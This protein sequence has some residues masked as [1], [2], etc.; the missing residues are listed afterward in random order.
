MTETPVR[1]RR[2]TV[3]GVVV[4]DKMHKTIVIQVERTVIHPVFKKYLRR[5]SKLT[6]HDANNDAGVGDKV[7]IM[8]T[9]P[10]SKTKSFRLVRIVSKAKIPASTPTIESIETEAPGE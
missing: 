10:I 3:T 2:R 4:S 5:R 7:E 6:A 1:S 8:A 9:R